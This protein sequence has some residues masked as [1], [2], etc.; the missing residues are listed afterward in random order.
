[1][2]FTKQSNQ[3]LLNRLEIPEGKLN[4]VLDTDT[5]NEID[6]QF[7][8][9]YALS[10]TNRLNVEAVY[11][12]P[13]SNVRAAAPG[14]GMEKSYEEILR[15]LSRMGVSPEGL[16]FKGS[17]RYLGSLETPCRSAAALD[18]VERAM[19]ARKPLYV[20]AIGAITNIASA[21]LLEPRIIEKIVVVWL[22]GHALYWPH[23]VEFN[24]KQDIQA[25]RLVFDC[26]VPV[27]Q[28]PCMAVAS[29]LITSVPELELY[30]EGK[31]DIGAYLTEI[32]RDYQQQYNRLTKEIWDISAVAALINPEW[33]PMEIV[34]SPVLTDQFTW[35]VDTRRHFIKTAR[36]LNRDA[37]FQDMF[38][39][40]C[41]K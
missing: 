12:A 19:A 3:L 39:K 20:V 7:A 38:T 8:L 18:L 14:E 36:N 22:G 9:V 26:G 24:L 29:H 37:I 27:I 31:N 28:I 11:A 17:D 32:F 10:S 6:D 35:S 21:I 41:S 5:Y 34:H 33:V 30:L 25:A 13:F 23:T 4:I 1:M 15:V 40:I 2:E 16:V